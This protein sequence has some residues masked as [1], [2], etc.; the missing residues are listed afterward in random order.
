M[1]V[2]YERKLEELK[3]QLVRMANLCLKNAE[4][5]V[6]ALCEGDV[7]AAAALQAEDKLVNK[8]EKEIEAQAFS[9]LLFEHPVAGDFR[10]VSSVLKMITD[11]ERIGD[12]AKDIAELASEKGGKKF[13][14]SIDSLVGT[15]FNMVRASIDAFAR[16]DLQQAERVRKEDDVVDALFEKMKSETISRVQNNIA[17]AEDALN[18]YMASKYL[19]RI[20]DHAVNL[21]EWVEYYKTGRR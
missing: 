12:H 5:A 9:L 14:H 20:A 8:M 1:S 19:E 15:V 6:R 13:G 21:C 2:A 18:F 17:D 4:K 10:E 16:G 7:E 3:V 11:L